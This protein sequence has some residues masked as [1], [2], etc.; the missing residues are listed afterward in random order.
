MPELVA[1]GASALEAYAEF[2][3]D[4]AELAKRHPG[5]AN[6]SLRAAPSFE[7]QLKTPPRHS[8]GGCSPLPEWLTAARALRA[9]VLYDS[10]RRAEFKAQDGQFAD[11]D[12]IDLDSYH[13]L[14]YDGEMLAGCVRVYHL[15]NEVAPSLTESLIGN[16]AF[17]DLITGLGGQRRD[18]VEIGRWIVHPEFRKDSILSLGVKLAASSAALATALG[19]LCDNRQGLAVCSVGTADKQ[20]AMLSRIGLKVMEN[21]RPIKNEHYNDALRICVCLGAET[22]SPSFQRLMETMASEI[23]VHA[24]VSKVEAAAV[25]R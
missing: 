25:G 2:L 13:I 15:L 1:A 7:F 12:P 19:N 17:S 11:P 24:A 5:D 6:D 22:L 23:G 9:Q 4:C 14:A 21:I 20:A 16:E 18:T 10:G 8:L 3:S